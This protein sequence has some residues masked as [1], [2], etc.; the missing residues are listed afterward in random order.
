MR[1]TGAWAAEEIWG[2]APASS[3]TARRVHDGIL[4]GKDGLLAKHL[5][6]LRAFEQVVELGQA[7]G[8]ACPAVDEGDLV[9]PWQTAC[10]H[11]AARSTSTSL[12]ETLWPDSECHAEECQIECEY[13]D[14]AT[15]R[16]P[17]RLPG[18]VPSPGFSQGETM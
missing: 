9:C 2:S 17:R 12:F 10:L 4:I 13:R 15:D 6:G 14:K 18:G 16:L 8:V 3:R 5:R 11:C 7:V 1:C